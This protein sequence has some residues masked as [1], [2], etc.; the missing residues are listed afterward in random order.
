MFVLTRPDAAA[1]AAL[2][3]TAARK[4]TTVDIPSLRD[5]L[6]GGAENRQRREDIVRVLS[7]DPVFSKV[8]RDNMSRSKLFMRGQAM[9]RRLHE[10]QN[11]LNW[12][13]DDLRRSLSI[14]D[15]T[16]PLTLH[17]QAF[18]P[19]FN[20]QA[21][22][23]LH[24][25]YSALVATRGIL[26]CYLQTELAH[27]TA[28][29]ALETTATYDPATREFELHSPSL[30][31]AKWWSGAAGRTAT[32]GVVQAQ[33][34]LPGGKRMGPHLFFVQLRS[35]EDHRPMRGVVLGD[36]G[37]KALGGF[38]ATDNGFV[39]FDRVRIPLKNMLSKFAQV[40]E[41]GEYVRPPHDKLAYGGMLYIR[42]G[43][44]T[45][46][47]M[48][49]A[50][51]ITIAI[52]YATVRRQ[53]TPSPDGLEPQVISYPSVNGRLMPILARAYVFLRLGKALSSLFTTIAARLASGDTS[54]LAE[55]HATTSGLKV[56]ATTT[57]I[58]DIE[59]ARR[60]A[61]GHGFSAA[62]GMGR[63]YAEWV[64]SAS[65]EGD[66]YVLDQQVVRAA[67]KAYKALKPGVKDLPP[68]SAYLQRLTG[69]ENP[70]SGFTF[71]SIEAL[72][73]D[74]STLVALLEWRAALVVRELA[75]A[76]EVTGMDAARVA[77]AVTD[78]F[79]AARVAEMTQEVEKDG[80]RREDA[81]VLRRLFVL[82]LLT[83]AEAA[84][85]DLL[86]HGILCGT[87]EVAALRG[88]IATT[89]ASLV[90]HA[91]GLTDAFGF[92]DWELDSALGM[93][94]GRVYEALWDRAQ[95]EPLNEK[96]VTDAYGESIKWVLQNGQRRAAEAQRNAKL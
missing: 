8:G 83:S 89:C 82:Y 41:A 29:S 66:N 37:P 90:P 73:A 67:L 45:G 75:N 51:A 49:T 17:F 87:Q 58:A 48:M 44:V 20:L 33:L 27:G 57:S 32:H 40:T 94:D 25:E 31:A 54:L 9:T 3:M 88:T 22:P 72:V 21:G 10:L 78:A 65:Y 13:N 18:E 92:S 56:F 60:S 30:T 15:E 5:Y 69:G 2:D 24:A 28:V 53:G 36:Q 16:L 47:G 12:S 68:S 63:V 43:M 70:P 64:P 52:R 1:Q 85:S 50:K 38:A 42:S 96:E 39:R 84:L 93:Y 46:A 55:L 14:L 19:V 7:A 61:G 76:G 71:T 91:I 23:A 77:R 59:S 79:V 26:G 35:L 95:R 80:V 86:V 74:P 81:G 4:A 62:A 6:H 11:K 34:I